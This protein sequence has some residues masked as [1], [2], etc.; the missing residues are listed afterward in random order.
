MKL[1]ALFWFQEAEEAGVFSNWESLVQ[2]LHVRYGSTAYDDPIE[3]L[4][5]LR[6]TSS[7]TL[8]KVKFEAVSNRIKG[9]SPLHKLS[10]FLS[11]LKGEIRLLVRVLNPQSL[12]AAFGLAK[13][14]EEYVLSCKRNAKYQQ[15]SG[16]NSTLGLPKGNVVVEAKPRIP[17]KRITRA[18]MDERRKRG[19]CYNCDDKWGLRH[20]WKNVKLFLLEGIDIVETSQSG[21]Q[22]TKLEE[23]VDSDVVTK[24]ARNNQSNQEEDVEITLYALTRT[25][26]PGTMRLRV[27][28][29]KISKVKVA[30]GSIVKA[31]G[32]CSTMLVCV[33]GVEFCIQFHVLALGGCDAVL[34]TQWLSIVGEIQWNFQLL[35]MCFCYG[36]KQVLLRV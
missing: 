33:Q 26:T 3:V 16:K 12:N 6:Q 20:I 2:A 7:V 19:L 22:I 17:I 15:E 34:C 4:T 9:L 30:N 8:Y 32:F 5:R 14:Q 1:K 13:S 23:D 27:D 21:V 35:T 18:Q 11:G 31:Q 25:P 24:I 28:V 29:T 36:S 10:C